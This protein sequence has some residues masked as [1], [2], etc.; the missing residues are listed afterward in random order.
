MKHFERLSRAVSLR[1]GII[2]VAAVV[3]ILALS[4]M[5]TRRVGLAIVAA[6]VVG[7]P[8]AK[9]TAAVTEHDGT[10]IRPFRVAVPDEALK[11]LHRRVAA[12]QWPERETVTDTTQGVQLATMQKLAR[13]GRRRTLA[14]SRSDAEFVPAVHHQHRWAPAAVP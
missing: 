10:A 4:S 14:K 6:S 7:L 5:A 9:A 11:D 1:T 12:T 2:I 3:V 13:T 8:S